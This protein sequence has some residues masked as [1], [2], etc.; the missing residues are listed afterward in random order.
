VITDEFLAT[1]SI[2]PATSEIFV[3]HLTDYTGFNNPVCINT[4]GIVNVNGIF[5]HDYFGKE[6]YATYPEVGTELFTYATSPNYYIDAGA[7]A[8]GTRYYAF[9]IAWS[10]ST[11]GIPDTET[12]P[13]SPLA[14]PNPFTDGFYIHNL[15]ENARLEI[16]DIHGKLLY[17][18][19]PMNNTL[20]QPGQLPDGVYF[21]KL[22]NSQGARYQKIVKY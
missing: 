15:P 2:C 12:N 18:A 20:V 6:G 16:F 19:E 1:L 3:T 4:D 7:T 21:L 13:A 22:I 17:Q 8:G 14:Y 5:G 11:D 9:A 10:N